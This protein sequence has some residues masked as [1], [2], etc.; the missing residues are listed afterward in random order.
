MDTN[1]LA[2]ILKASLGDDVD[3]LLDT[4]IVLLASWLLH[5][6]VRAD[7]NGVEAPSGQAPWSG[8]Y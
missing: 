3:P 1:T 5:V 7:I 8:K 2:A 6:F 4:P